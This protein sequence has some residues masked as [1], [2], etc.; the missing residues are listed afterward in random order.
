MSVVL[1]A[2]PKSTFFRGGTIS[3]LE[4]IPLLCEWMGRRGWSS[5]PPSSATYGPPPPPSPIRLKVASS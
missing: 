2:V 1:E 4:A 3:R 5:G